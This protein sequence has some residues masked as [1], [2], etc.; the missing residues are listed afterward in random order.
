MSYQPNPSARDPSFNETDP[1]RDEMRAARLNNRP[2]VYVVTPLAII[3]VVI[4][5]FLWL[6]PREVEVVPTVAGTPLDSAFSVLVE[7]G[8]CVDWVE[9]DPQARAGYVS[10]QNPQG[11][12]EWTN[13]ARVVRLIIGPTQDLRGAIDAAPGIAC[14]G[15]RPNLARRPT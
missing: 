14:P 7:A 3:A 15:A 12:T 9:V 13:D 1:R 8:V 11:D 4:A 5:V 10:G 6:A 2:W